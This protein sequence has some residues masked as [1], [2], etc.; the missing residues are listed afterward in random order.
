M[1]S[2][3]QISQAERITGDINQLVDMVHVNFNMQQ[4]EIENISKAKQAS[5]IDAE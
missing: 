5:E 3:D 2:P 4:Q 1:L